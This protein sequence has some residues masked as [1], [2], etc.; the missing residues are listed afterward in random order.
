MRDIQ[1]KEQ[2]S[3]R[4]SC[5]HSSVSRVKCA[6]LLFVMEKKKEEEKNL[7][8]TAHCLSLV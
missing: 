5:Q 1:Q 8:L 2:T 7:A 3:G 6:V 4:T